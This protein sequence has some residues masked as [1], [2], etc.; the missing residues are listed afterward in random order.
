MAPIKLGDR[1]LCPQLCER[2]I[3]DPFPLFWEEVVNM[4]V[5]FSL[6]SRRT[7]WSLL[8][9]GFV[10]AGARVG[11]L[12]PRVLVRKMHGVETQKLSDLSEDCDPSFCL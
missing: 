11:V 12:R 7:T 2:D 10:L 8:L 5:I 9:V 4:A 1:C 3:S 6:I